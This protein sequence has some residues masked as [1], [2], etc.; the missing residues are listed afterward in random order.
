MT[1]DRRRPR[2]DAALR[3]FTQA[4]Q[5]ALELA[6]V[7]RLSAPEHTPHDVVHAQP[8]YRLRHYPGAPAGAPA[9]LLV[10][11]LMVTAD[12]YDIAHDVSAVR[13]LLGHGVD[14]WL[15]DFGAPE[16]EDGGLR[17]TLDDHVRA[18]ADAIARVRAQVGKAV[19]VGGYSQGGL[20][21]YQGA[22]LRRGD[23]VASIIGFGPPVDIHKNALGLGDDVTAELAAGLAT[24][25]EKPLAGLEALPGFVTSTGFKLLSARK[26]LGQLVE[27]VRLLHDREALE[28]REAKR[29]FLGGQGF[30]AWPGPALRAFIDE[31]IVANRMMSGGFVIDGHT[32]TLAD[33]T[34]PILIFVGDRDEFARPEAVRAIREAAPHAE[35]S[36]I[37]LHAG[38]LGLVVGTVANTRTWPAVA[39]WLAWREGKGSRPAI[40]DEAAA[41]AAHATDATVDAEPPLARL[42][43]DVALASE[44]AGQA[45]SALW[46]R[47]QARV[48]GWA[49]TF[50][51]LR[52]QVPRLE[53]LR[54]MTP[55]TRVSFGLALAE[56]ARLHAHAPFVLW[57][58]RAVS[59]AQAQARVDAVA[60]GLYQLGVRPGAQVAVCMGT[61]PSALVAI[62]ALSRLGAVA[63]C[64]PPTLA[65]D[66]LRTVLVRLGPSALIC[67]PERAA[68][69]RAAFDGALWL[70]GGVGEGA[71]AR[72]VPT[73]ALD[74]EALD[75]ADV[76]IPSDV[77][78]QGR[79]SDLAMR[80]VGDVRG[81][82]EPRVTSITNERW[83]LSAYGAA[84][85]CALWARDTVAT[86]LP[87]HHASGALVAASAAL[88]GEARLLLAPPPPRDRFAEVF[89]DE[90]R[91]NG[92]TVVF[93]A[94]Q[95]ARAL[96]DAPPAPGERSHP[97]RL[98]AGSGMPR[99]VW[100]RLDA[101]FGRAELVEFW[102]A[103]EASAVL[104]NVGQR[105]GA[106][107]RPLPGSAPLALAAFD[108]RTGA[109]GRDA[110]GQVRAA[111][112]GEVGELLV[113]VPPGHLDPRVTSDVFAP[114]DAWLRTGDLMRKDAAGDHWFVERARDLLRLPDGTVLW[115]SL[116]EA[117][118][119]EVPGIRQAVLVGARDPRGAL[120]PLVFVSLAAG[121]DEAAVAAA[122]TQALAALPVGERPRA[123][124]RDDALP[125][126]EGY[127][128]DRRELAARPWP[129]AAE[130]WGSGAR[131]G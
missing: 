104:A 108:A 82:G 57:Q 21:V 19:H 6:R 15:V 130:R 120:A 81:R 125:M 96:V 13:A 44:V 28:R 8:T 126:T 122:V 53:R 91:R 110:A 97:I 66:V 72:A 35:V 102:A 24:L 75:V 34:C 114:G 90:V 3:R 31:F 65:P 107:G 36:E 106:V 118:L 33:L 95:M 111:H 1:D 87:L 20:F 64:C 74:L 69:G 25:L 128:P 7:G 93:Y 83:A 29:L 9:L 78:D 86:S 56:R 14:P 47:A 103:T 129:T 42:R 76:I 61:R 68:A 98:W 38:H 2:L 32:V 22:A 48:R 109:L 26:E 37:G 80:L 55:D 79:A 70:L 46:Q 51:S 60:R 115:P 67:D 39:D 123:L 16:R 12:V 62:A 45:A 11:P 59:A 85:T 121:S 58:G 99:D 116:I 119:L 43:D 89:W 40:L 101:R 73:G 27:F 92:A 84:A 17:R 52:T 117:A 88:V 50:E 131:E 113:R 10:P 4:A 112:E 18:V 5:N 23:G 63:V 94:G 105:P 77:R 71:P 100:R 124:V 127:Q 30:V 41:A 49:G 54:R